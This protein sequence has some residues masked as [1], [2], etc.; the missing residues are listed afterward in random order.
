[1]KLNKKQKLFLFTQVISNQDK[2]KIFETD[3]V[4]WLVS[5]NVE[6]KEWYRGWKR[7]IVDGEEYTQLN[8]PNNPDWSEILDNIDDYNY[9]QWCGH[10][11]PLDELTKLKKWR[12][13]DRCR[14]YLISRGE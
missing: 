3:D 12:L 10:W 1:M 9:C 8:F 11:F 2:V 4:D 5:R 6:L 7:L 14:T 13:C